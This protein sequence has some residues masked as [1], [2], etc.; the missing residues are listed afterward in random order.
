MDF[1]RI[2]V[3]VGLTAE[4]RIARRRFSMIET[5]G[6]TSAGA[7]AAAQRLIGRGAQGLISFGLAGG[8]DPALRPGTVIVPE[9]VLT[10]S[11]VLPTCPELIA[12]RLTFSAPPPLAGGSR[13]EGEAGGLTSRPIERPAHRLLG[14]DHVVAS[15]ARK[16]ALWLTSGCA[17]VD[18]ESGPVA[19]AALAH[20]LPFAVLRA[21]CDPAERDLPPAAL[22]ALNDIGAIGLVRVIASVIA[23]PGQIPPLL[24]LAQDAAAARRALIGH[25]ANQL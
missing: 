10:R 13:G 17:A 11:G 8:L 21:I 23:H 12:T 18:L 6:G 4:A 1:S 9:A 5:G 25:L 2:G 3:V 7:E 14:G 20:G 16:Q 22:S 15:A 24:T 19:L